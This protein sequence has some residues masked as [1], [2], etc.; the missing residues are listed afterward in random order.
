VSG[1]GKLDGRDTAVP[2]GPTVSTPGPTPDD[3]ERGQSTTV[4]TQMIFDQDDGAADGRGTF[5]SVDSTPR[6]GE[7]VETARYAHAL[8]K[9]TRRER[10]ALRK[11]KRRERSTVVGRHPKTTVLLVI[12]V[13]LTP[14]WASLGSAATNPALGPTVGSRLTEWTRDH[15]GGGIVTWAENTWYTWNAPPK[16]GKPAAGAIPKV[17][18]TSTT[19]PVATGPAHLSAPAAIV[20]FVAT[21]TPGE[22]QWHP[23]GRTVDGIPA[24]YA[25]YLRPNAVYTSLVTGVAWMDTKLLRTTLYAGSTIPGTG[26]SFATAAPITGS[27][28]DSL[29][30]AFNSGFRMQ[31]SQGGFYLDGIEARTLVP[32]KA[33]LVIDSAG[34]VTIGSWGTEVGMSP[35]TVAVRQNL[36]LVVDNGRVVPGLDANDNIKWGATLG[37]GVHVWR[38]GVGVTADGALV[39]AGGS[40]LSIV[41]LASVLQRAGSVRAMELDINTSWVNF[42]HWDLSYGASATSANGT[43]LTYDEATYPSRYF[44]SLSRDFFTESVRPATVPAATSH[45]AK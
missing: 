16:G 28:L 40:G 12:L 44:S 1:R 8:A 39:Y 18:A 36:D 31:D 9:P 24:M 15:G 10:R 6:R 35:S 22:G 4:P 20:P 21:P 27:A 33:S 19:V 14:V 42:S 38:S 30:A 17:A 7:S 45:F 23:I 11:Q 26:Q 5:P 43:K 41:D 25:A 29:D 37:G 3:V 32:G 13:L 34:N 2:G